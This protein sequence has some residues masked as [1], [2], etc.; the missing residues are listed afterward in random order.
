MG[1]RVTQA[2]IWDDFTADLAADLRGLRPDAQ[3]AYDSLDYYSRWVIGYDNPEYTREN[4]GLLTRIYEAIQYSDDDL[5]IL[6]PRGSAKSSAVTI[7]ATTWLIGRN[8]NL[9]I[10]IAV[11]SMKAQGFAFMRQI[12]QIF[13]R[14][15]R[16]IEVFGNLKPDRPDKWDNTEKIVARDAPASGL[17][18]PTIA[19]AGLDSAVPSKRADIVITDDLVTAENA[20]S[21]LQRLKVINFTFLTLFPILVPTGRRWLVG[22][23]YAD[24]DLYEYAAETWG[25]PLPKM[26]PIDVAQYIADHWEE[27]GLDRQSV[28]AFLGR[29]QGQIEIADER[30]F[31]PAEMPIGLDKMQDIVDAIAKMEGL[32]RG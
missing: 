16:Y 12:D 24:G 32:A 22:T 14:N 25:V 8:P 5:L 6:A 29:Q 7:T 31:D 18:D 27:V 11:A 13:T 3:A 23:R 10:L 17:K 28:E 26:P 30:K 19:V 2:P 4:S 21:R 1:A 20:A 9:R 15:E